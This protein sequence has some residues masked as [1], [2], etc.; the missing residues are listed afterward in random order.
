[1]HEIPI[2][3][4][5]R[6]ISNIFTFIKKSNIIV[7]PKVVSRIQIFF[8]FNFPKCLSADFKKK[9]VILYQCGETQN[10]LLINVLGAFYL[11]LIPIITTVLSWTYHVFIRT[12]IHGLTI[13]C[14]IAF[15]VAIYSWWVFLKLPLFLPSIKIASS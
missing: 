10:W 2:V 13:H 8:G 1:M 7:I 14:F 11:G 5:I 3:K 12:F 4:K 15:F 9:M 6:R